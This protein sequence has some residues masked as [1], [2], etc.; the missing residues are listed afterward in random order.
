MRKHWLLLLPLACL[1]GTALADPPPAYRAEVEQRAAMMFDRADTNH[2][3]VLT[4]D[5]YV[6]AT[7]ALAK[8]RGGT[9]TE[10]GIALVKAQFDAFDTSHTGRISR[11]DFLAETMAHF[12]SAD[13]N[14]D[15]IVT[16]DEARKAAEKM[17]REMQAAKKAGTA[18]AQ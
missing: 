14:H 6:A 10:K 5:E 13:L 11:A 16:A 12:D 8:A 15:G 2:D 7:V 3:G 4:R 17:R 1:A 18:P 9:P